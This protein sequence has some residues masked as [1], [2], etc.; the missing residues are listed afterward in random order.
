M[1][2]L[3]LKKLLLGTSVLAG[4]AAMSIAAPAY[5]Q[6]SDE[7]PVSI[8]AVE[9]V[10][11]DEEG[12]E[13]VVTGSRLKKNTFSSTAP[14][15]VIT[16]DDANQQGLFSPV[17]ILQTNA[18]ASGQQID[19][20][21]S[22]FVLDN[23]PGS[24][25]INLR[26]LGADRTLVLMNGRRL[27]PAGVEG[28]PTQPSINL[29]PRTMVDRFDLLLD[30]ASAVY[31]SD[32]VAGVV[33]V[34]LKNDYDG[35]ELDFS[36]D[37]PE[38]GAGQDYTIGARYGINGDRGFIGGAIEYDYEEPWTTGDRDFLDGCE[39]YR[40]VT[41]NGEIRTVDIS[42][43]LIA[44]GTGIDAPVSP[45]RA[46][47][48]T[49]RFFI[50]D[51]ANGRLRN[52]GSIYYQPDISNT[53]IPGYSESTQFGAA[54]DGNG[55]G[56]RDVNFFEF[57]PNAQQ[58]D[59]A[60]I[61]PEQSGISFFANGEYTFEGEMNITPYFETLAVNRQIKQRG[62][63][64]QLFPEVPANNPFNPCNFNAGGV[65]CSAAFNNAVTDPGFV[66]LFQNYYNNPDFSAFTGTG[67]C[68]GR[69][70]S[71][72]CS[73]AGFGLTRP[74]GR[75]LSVQPIVGIRGDRTDFAVDT[76]QT[77]I[78]G[79][80]RGDLPGIN[81]GSLSDWEFD[82][83]LS[84]TWSKG[85]SER[86]GVREDRLNFALG[87][88]PLVPTI[89]GEVNPLSAPCQS[90]NL[91]L[92]PD[93]TDG[94][95]PVNLFA[96]S[97]MGVAVGGEFAT[98]AERDYVFDTRSFDTRY[99]QLIVD[100]TAQGNIMELPGGT[101]GLLV[102]VQLR[103]DDLDSQPNAV[104]S[105]GQLFG[106]F[107]DEGAT[108][109]RETKEAF[110]EASFPLGTG[111]LGFR[112][113]NLDVAGRYTDD[114]F[115]GSNNTYSVKAGYRPIDSL[116]LKATYGT[117]FR[118]PNLRE[119]FLRN[120]SGFTN[121]FDVCTTPEGAFS[122]ATPDSPDVYD[123]G[124]DGRT[125]V[126]LD[127]CRQAGLDPTNY[128]VGRNSYQVELF[129]SGALAQQDD[130]FGPLQPETSESLTLGFS[131]DQPFTDAFD[132]RIGATYFDLEIQDSIFEASGAFITAQCYGSV[133]NL[134]S[135]FCALLDRPNGRDI[136]ELRS[137]FFNLDSETAQFADYNFAFNKDNVAIA[138]KS[139]DIF[140]RGQFSQ[141]IER[142]NSL[143]IPN[144]G[145]PAFVD[146]FVGEFAVPEW[147]GSLTYGATMDRWQG[148]LTTRYISAVE[149]QET[150]TRGQPSRSVED[151][152]NPFDESNFQGAGSSV[153]CGGPTFGDVN[154]RP[155]FSA[156]DYFVH[157]AS[158]TYR[159]D[160]WNLLMGVNNLFND[161]PPLVSP[162]EV[163][164]VSNVPLGAGYD[165]NGREYF[166]RVRK[167]FR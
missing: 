113:F 7:E 5:A 104:A 41:E 162:R 14:I 137:R 153:T 36:I 114:E 119:L 160:D 139:I 45:C 112:E 52:F 30:G 161:A 126:L 19:S 92:S 129:R 10:I 141:Y 69:G 16:T 33:N 93:V 3:D 164:S 66:Q 38:T 18:A 145:E 22:G 48:L 2:Q 144:D 61:A 24:E 20:T 34:I 28:A 42:D 155:V 130:L 142:E 90:D 135:P 74:E 87:V 31:G 121:F 107:V 64:G 134:A 59:L 95:V 116:L 128:R 147:N 138:G 79:G 110:F 115:Y 111:Q 149:S 132:L 102:G 73:L 4:F 83:S 152:T 76:T 37:S 49:Q 44:R 96:P 6:T 166:V 56:I 25:T 1:T 63:Q 53:G 81:F 62:R 60:Q 54:F 58:V 11:D 15:Q 82:S 27:A 125:D 99:S 148:A 55:D 131:F 98:Q 94:C 13:V 157:S 39:T 23:G 118:A 51:F 43:Q 84:Y 163:G 97:I 77:R 150:D 21:F 124:L 108:G 29:I 85:I 65:D 122:R 75:L 105:Q 72:A 40:E 68:Y 71:A 91:F 146:T 133:A 154:C 117:S 17:D 100:L 156:D 151:F 106:F 78:L 35:L 47:R 9:D 127:N 86:E 88:N 8:E 109:T 158:V 46:T 67:N 57:S 12:D 26:A 101:A 140:A 89:F 103:E 32:A 165:L 50:N 143:D 80:V 159:G 120:Q 136:T 123:R 70:F 167:T